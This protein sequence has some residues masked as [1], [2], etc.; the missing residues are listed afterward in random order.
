MLC[1]FE[2]TRTTFQ[3]WMFHYIIFQYGHI[4]QKMKSLT[5]T[6]IMFVVNGLISCVIESALQFAEGEQPATEASIDST[7]I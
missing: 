6:R 2:A 4:A 1:A 5:N 3:E 7:W